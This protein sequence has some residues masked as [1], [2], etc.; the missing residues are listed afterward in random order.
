[1]KSGIFVSALI[2]AAFAQV[3]SAEA[4]RRCDPRT[5]PSGRRIFICHDTYYTPNL[6]FRANHLR[7]SNNC[8]TVQT[9]YG[10]RT[11]CY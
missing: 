10:L 6:E 5:L 7:R 9:Q 1:M 3:Q 2:V 8:S 4:E 11:Y